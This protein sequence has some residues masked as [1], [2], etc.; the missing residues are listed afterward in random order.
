LS[1]SL[2]RKDNRVSYFLH[3]WNS[4]HP[5]VVFWLKVWKLLVE[6][7]TQP[8]F[9]YASIPTDFCLFFVCCC[10]QPYQLGFSRDHRL[11]WLGLHLF[12]FILWHLVPQCH[13]NI[14][15]QTTKKSGPLKY[16]IWVLKGDFADIIATTQPI[17]QKQHN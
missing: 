14:R 9:R 17:T 13:N 2:I 12:S 16:W 10:P 6:A 1:R 5:T 11:V 7:K 3:R 8:G 4:Y 15:I